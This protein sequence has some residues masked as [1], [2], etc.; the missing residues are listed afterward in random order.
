MVTGPNRGRF[1]DLSDEIV[2]IGRGSGSQVQIEDPS[3]SSAHARIVRRDESF[4]LEDLSSRNGTFLNSESVDVAELRFGDT[5]QIGAS[6]MV[7]RSDRD[8]SASQEK[9]GGAV[10]LTGAEAG[11]DASLLWVESDHIVQTF[12]FQPG[13]DDSRAEKN[14]EILYEV[15]RQCHLVRRPEEVLERI[16]VLLFSTFDADRAFAMILDPREDGSYDQGL[17]VVCH[18]DGEGQ[19][20]GISRRIIDQAISTRSPIL[21]YDAMADTRFKA[22]DSVMEHRMRSVLC[23]PIIRREKVLGLVHLDS[24]GSSGLFGRND[25]D[26]LKAISDEVAVTVENARLYEDL[27]RVSERNTAILECLGDGLLVVDTG[28][29]VTR[30]NRRAEEIFGFPSVTLVGKGIS[31]FEALREVADRVGRVLA[32]GQRVETEELVLRPGGDLERPVR[33][34]TSALR[35]AGGCL[36]GVIVSVHD[37]TEQRD[38]VRRLRHTERLAAMGEAVAGVAHELRN[39]LT[40]IRSLTQ[41]IMERF[42]SEDREHSY[43]E[44]ILDGIDRASRIIQELLSFARDTKLEMNRMDPAAILSAVVQEQENLLA[45]RGVQ[46]ALTIDDDLPWVVADDDKLRQILLNL[47]GNASDACAQGG[48]IR[49]EARKSEGMVEI[50]VID[51]GEGIP[52]EVQQRIFD[53]FYTSKETGTGLGLYISRRL[54][55]AQGGELAV[56]SEVGV[57]SAFTIRIPDEK[58]KTPTSR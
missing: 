27:E 24:L 8:G 36:D 29:R 30:L 11:A 44:M 43:G 1:Y 23:A 12:Q 34:S 39:P 4:L 31:E 22:S 13:R 14:L 56:T 58:R 33:V 19:E 15:L 25:L 48:T 53:P 3:A 47:L 49:V 37:M 2:E 21:S 42:T 20:I 18:R 16:L 50:G 40:V 9:S 6:Q 57:G 5:I 26:L 32:S 17:T 41:V 35:G 45:G 46:I 55:E 38:L 28:G 51:D 7:F 54:T 52:P 10:H